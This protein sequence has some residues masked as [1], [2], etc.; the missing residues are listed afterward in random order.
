MIACPN[1]ARLFDF[2][3]NTTQEII[4]NLKV[5]QRFYAPIHGYVCVALCVF[6]ILTNLV[7]VAVLSRPSMRS[8][9]VNCLLTAV[10]I[11]DL[12]T[13]GTYLIYIVH[14]VVFRHDKCNPTFTHGWMQFLL[15]HVVL[16][17]TLH[18]TSLWL[19][20]AMAFVRRMTLRVA[21]LNSKWQ[22][23]GIAWKVSLVVYASVFLLCAPNMLVHDIAEYTHAVWRPSQNC[24]YPVNYTEK[25]Y[26][27]S[28]SR[29]ATAN[30]CRIFK[31]NIW[32]IGIV[33]KVIPC[34]LL[35]FLSIGLM[36]K[37]RDAERNRRK[38]TSCSS[39]SSYATSKQSTKTD[40]TTLMLVVILIVFLIT[41]LPQGIISILC[42]IYT[43]DVH[44]YLYYYLGDVLDLLSLLNSSVNFVLYCIMS[45]RYR[46]T[47]W[48]VVLPS[49]IYKRMWQNRN[50]S[51][52][53]NMVSRK[54]SRK[55]VL[56]P[57]RQNR[58]YTL[59][60]TTELQCPSTPGS[61][62]SNTD[63]SSSPKIEHL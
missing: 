38:L 3:D 34:I 49:S 55:S 30:N 58:D 37:L 51:Q 36:M 45:S 62:R 17:I 7:H 43:A 32:M 21:R 16:S 46:K 61:L 31:A 2:N 26:T 13:M 19:A 27:F 14:F 50:A 15:W 41:E 60:P 54:A 22:R 5:F 29:V 47:F 4:A 28:I 35:L 63:S 25:I 11:C 20:V 6:G 53:F 40:R 18:S 23:P 9:A 56:S 52:T 12:G 59:L 48:T 42:A 24:N 10:A 39:N 8:S 33:F 57:E 44:N 1:D